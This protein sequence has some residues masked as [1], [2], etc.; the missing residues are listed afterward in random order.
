MVNQVSQ[1]VENRGGVDC[2]NCSHFQVT[3]DAEFPRGCR[4]MGFKSRQWPWMEVLQTSGEP[5]L[6]FQ[7]KEKGEFPREKESV[8]PPARGGFSRMV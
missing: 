1:A 4:A 3:W 7:P 6:Q 8:L 2:R 5:C